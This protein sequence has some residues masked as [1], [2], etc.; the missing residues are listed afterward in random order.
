[1]PRNDARPEDWRRRLR[2]DGPP[3]RLLLIE[4]NAATAALLRGVLAWHGFGGPEVVA[5]AEEALDVLGALSQRVD[6]VLVS[7]PTHDDAG[8]RVADVL[9]RCRSPVRLAG[10]G[11]ALASELARP[12]RLAGAAAYIDVLARRGIARWTHELLASPWS[13]RHILKTSLVPP[14]LDAAWARAI[15]GALPGKPFAAD[16]LDAAHPSTL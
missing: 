16:R 4:P 10:Y 11:G 15:Y 14:T 12:T 8:A 2:A 7:L 6:L 3:A 13:I 1:M 9:R 5:D